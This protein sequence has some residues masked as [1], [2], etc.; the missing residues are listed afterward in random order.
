M[1]KRD[2]EQK[3]GKIESKKSGEKNKKI[4]VGLHTV[5]YI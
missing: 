5:F 4:N 3:I 1:E 2:F